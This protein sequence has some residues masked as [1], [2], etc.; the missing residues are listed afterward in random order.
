MSDDGFVPYGPPFPYW[1]GP[2]TPARGNRSGFRV[3]SGHLV[4]WATSD[5]DH[6]LWRVE[7]TPGIVQLER[8][9][10]EHW[11]GGRVLLLPNGL[12]IKPLAQDDERGRRVVIGQYTNRVKLNGPNRDVLDL[13][14]LDYLRSGDEWPGPGTIGIECCIDSQGAI[15]CKW[16]IPTEDGWESQRLEV[17]PANTSLEKGFRRVRPWATGGRVRVT[18]HGVVLTMRNTGYG[19]KAH[20]VGRIDPATWPNDT[21]WMQQGDT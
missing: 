17:S 12:V 5:D 21:S 20:Y 16:Y 8:V 13:T 11:H 7:P 1:L 6:Y 15:S 14:G 3:Q 18:G 19:W 4:A 9:V 2:Y 10:R